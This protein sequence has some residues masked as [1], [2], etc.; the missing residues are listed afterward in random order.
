MPIPSENGLT[1]RK[2]SGIVRFV[3]EKTGQQNCNK[4]IKQNNG[5]TLEQIK[6][7]NKTKLGRKFVAKSCTKVC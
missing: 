6:T 7:Q 1:M 2:G 3:S 4:N 5:D